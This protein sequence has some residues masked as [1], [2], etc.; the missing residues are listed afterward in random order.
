[1][2]ERATVTNPEVALVDAHTQRDQIGNIQLKFRSVAE[3]DDVVNLQ[4]FG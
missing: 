3:R 1:M 2:L 4:P